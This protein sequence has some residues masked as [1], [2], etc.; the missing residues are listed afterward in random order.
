MTSIL[1]TFWKWVLYTQLILIA[2]TQS[3]WPCQG[4]H[5]QAL[6]WLKKTLIEYIVIINSIILS[7]INT[8]IMIEQ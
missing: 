1:C 4:L 2:A 3:V 5:K 6:Y 8:I 7:I